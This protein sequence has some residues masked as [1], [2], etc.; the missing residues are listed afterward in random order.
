[1]VDVSGQIDKTT[2]I[3]TRIPMMIHEALPSLRSAI[4]AIEVP[5]IALVVDMFAKESFAIA[6]ELIMPKY[7]FITSN[8]WFLS[9][10]LHAPNLDKEVDQ[11]DHINSQR[12]LLIPGWFTSL[13]VLSRF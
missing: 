10:T 6:E 7:V 11:G 8:A 1:M 9:L 12:T 3:S 4:L 2:S 13:T 5:P